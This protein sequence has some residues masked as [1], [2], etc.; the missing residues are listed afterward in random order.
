MASD[1]ARPVTY[2]FYL[3]SYGGTL[4]ADAF[5][6]FGEGRVGGVAVGNFKLTNYMEKGDR[7]RG[8][9]RDRRC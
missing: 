4:P 6:E 2:R 5:A 9:A 8:G 3:D 7:P 1:G